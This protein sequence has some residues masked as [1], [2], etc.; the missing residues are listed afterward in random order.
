MKGRSHVPM[1]KTVMR[2]AMIHLKP[3]YMDRVWGGRALEEQ[4]G[5][6][7][8]EALLPYGESWEVVD[9][10]GQQSVVDGGRFDGLTLHELWT[11]YR[12]EVFGD[13]APPS[14]R[15][16][17]L[18]KILDARDTLSLQV[19]PPI[20]EAAALHGEPK[21]EMWVIARAVP[22]ACVYAGVEA[23]V[24]RR[25]FAK[26]LADGTV[27]SLVPQIPVREGDFI[28]IPSGRLHAIG[29]G[30]LIF[31]IQQNSDTTYRVF[32]WN[33]LGLD[34]KPRDLHVEES[35]R[36]IDFTDESPVL[37][38]MQADG[39][40]ATCAFF[41][42]HRREVA[43]GMMVTLGGPGEFVMPGMLSGQLMSGHTSLQPG[44]WAL[45]PAG[46][47]AAARQVMAGPEGAVW[48]EVGFGR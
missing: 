4:Y 24:T 29:A 23:G 18:I 41:T 10:S 1:Q 16:P 31:E 15:F 8:P 48:L 47:D 27:A 13:A 30:L 35:L 2:P 22:E 26:A 38:T 42:V 9:R 37:G 12:E 33:R 19:H 43:A 36:C 14:K 11:G 45:V 32:D 21:T 5:R 25:S 6:I 3:L 44:A 34:G 40:L 46:A 20:S 39:L 7:L 28:F 17:L